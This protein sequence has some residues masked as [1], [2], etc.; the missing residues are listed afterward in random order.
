MGEEVALTSWLL[1]TCAMPTITGI[2]MQKPVLSVYSEV[3]SLW[4]DKVADY[5]IPDI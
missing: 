5:V 4:K 1:Y 2:R 3:K